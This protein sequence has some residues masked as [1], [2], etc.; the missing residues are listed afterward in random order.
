MHGSWEENKKKELCSVLPTR[1]WKF[2]IRNSKVK[3]LSVILFLLM[4]ETG[5]LYN[6]DSQI[7]QNSKLTSSIRQ[8]KLRI[9]YNSKKKPTQVTKTSKPITCRSKNWGS[10]CSCTYDHQ[11]NTNLNPHFL[12]KQ[13]I[14]SQDLPSSLL[15]Q[16][17]N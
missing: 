7:N 17:S 3:V 13:E 2:N 14:K 12:K 11:H 16:R 9:M 8:S 15:T 6:P 5:I 10:T 1:L 4:I